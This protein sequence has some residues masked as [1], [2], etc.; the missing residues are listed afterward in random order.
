LFF[1]AHEK[2]G[3]KP[4]FFDATSYFYAADELELLR[5]EEEELLTLEELELREELELLSEELELLELE[6]RLEELELREL[7]LLEELLK[8]VPR[9]QSRIA[10]P[11]L[12][13][14]HL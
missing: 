12:K 5:D 3:P 10:W 4:A 2:S 1:V 6:L 9:M 14:V 13:N 11:W 7:E 8:W